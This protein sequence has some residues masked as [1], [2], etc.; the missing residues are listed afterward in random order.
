[1]E[2]VGDPG[3]REIV[4]SAIARARTYGL[5]NR[6]PVRFFLELT[7]TFGSGFDSD[8]QLPWASN[9]LTDRSI[10]TDMLRAERLHERMMVY[11][12]H[13]AGPEQQHA[14]DALKKFLE[15][16]YEIAPREGWS[17]RAVL[18]VM[19]HLY[20]QKYEF[21]GEKVASTLTKRAAAEAAQYS[22][23]PGKGA[24]VLAGMMFA[25]GHQICEDPLYP[26]VAGALKDPRIT[27]SEG[28][29]SRLIARLR[30]YGAHVL[31]YFS[32]S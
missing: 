11:L 10:Q 30:T 20:P 1:M 8:P 4:K 21:I 18:M 24:A 32:K 7:C 16:K 23:P 15:F 22:L 19:A 26:W 12:D 3:A 28:R 29:Q 9:T 13:V 25:M 27:D 6:G 5:E 17:E 2:V 14:I 31:A